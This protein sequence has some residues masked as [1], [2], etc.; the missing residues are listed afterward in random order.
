MPKTATAQPS[1]PDARLARGLKAFSASLSDQAVIDAGVGLFII[2][3]L[4]F[5]L[6][7][8]YQRVRVEQLPEGSA[9]VSTI[10]AHEDLKVEDAAQTK[11]LRDQ[12]AASVLPVFDFNSRNAR[13]AT[14]TLEQLFAI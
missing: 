11:L 1:R 7:R 3:A 2:V 13:E 14:S 5:L 6:L 12:V 4:S 9:A 8:D 10:I